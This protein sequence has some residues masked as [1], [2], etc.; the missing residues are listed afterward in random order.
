L[1]QTARGTFVARI[2]ITMSGVINQL[3]VAVDETSS[4]SLAHP[5]SQLEAGLLPRAARGLADSARG[6]AAPRVLALFAVGFLRRALQMRAADGQIGADFEGF[7]LFS[8]PSNVRLLGYDVHRFVDQLAA[9]YRAARL[10]AIVSANEQFGA[11]AAAL[12]ARRLGLPGTD[13]RAVLACQHKAYCR[14]RL[15]QIAPEANAAYWAFPYTL[16]NDAPLGLPLPFFVKPVKATFS[17]LA[18]RIDS[19]DALRQ[20]LDFA[21]HERLI[22]KRLVKPFNDA[23]ARLV[24]KPEGYAIDAHWMIA[25]TRLAG[26][27]LNLD[28][29]VYK[30]EVRLLGCI[31]EIMY[32][33]TDAFARFQYPSRAP[34]SVQA[35]ARDLTT[36]IMQGLGFDHGFFNIEF[37]HDP[38]TDRLTVIEINPRLASQLADFY[39]RVDGLRTFDMQ[40]ALAQGKDPRG[41]PRATPTAGVAASFVWRAF[42]GNPP[43]RADRA[44]LRWLADRDPQALLFQFHKRGHG[45]RREYKWLGS[46]RY[47]TLNLGAADESSLHARYQEICERLG[48]PAAD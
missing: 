36:R 18:R 9:R 26:R 7:D 45:L 40:I 43:P 21:P 24:G 22:I 48:W 11:L 6:G 1:P 23:F 25:E 27:Q 17:V 32:P 41:V 35:R 4:R 31:D 3:A 10:D 20:H 8:F 12:L 19:R 13:P 28:G 46:H 39:E 47:A 34:S 33:G 42:D 44:A 29:Y 30:G 14:R 2:V 5:M 37:M 38:A 16:G 15:Q